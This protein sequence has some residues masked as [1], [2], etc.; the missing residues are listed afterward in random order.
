[1]AISKEKKQQQVAVIKEL[2]DKAHAVTIAVNHGVESNDMNALRVKARENNVVL[3]VAKNN[4]TR[5]VFNDS[6][7]FNV[8]CEDLKN[9]VML[10]FSM[11]DLSSSTKVLGEFSKV[12]DKLT[13]QA[14][15]IEG[16]RYG[17]DNIKYVMNLPN[18]EQA[19]CMVVLGVKSPLVQFS[20]V[21]QE[22][23]GQ[24]ARVLHAVSEQKQG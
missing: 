6:E 13:V 15:A 21:L 18:R 24:F 1:M 14:A 19:I 23:Y 9:P 22:L 5:R 11:E 10:G 4:L 12:N 3:M 17:A 7:Q 16:I 8:V 20:G 2:A